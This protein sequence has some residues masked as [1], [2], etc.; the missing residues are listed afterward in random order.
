MKLSNYE[1]ET[2]GLW[3]EAEKTASIY[4]Y[5]ATL[6]A[7]LLGLCGDY[8]EQVRQTGDNG[9]GGMTFEL[10]KKWI[11]VTPPRILS[12]A[13]REVLERMN[14]KRWGHGDCTIAGTRQCPE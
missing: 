1:K 14:Q 7:Q 8:P 11:K 6:K 9:Y 3:N 4:T 13:Q 10:P 12:P 5:N 2:V